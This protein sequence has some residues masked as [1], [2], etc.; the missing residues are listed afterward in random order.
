MPWLEQWHNELDPS[1]GMGMGQYFRSFIEEEA[2]AL[3]LTLAAVRAWKPPARARK[4]R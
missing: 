2:R 3:E 1:F 4:N